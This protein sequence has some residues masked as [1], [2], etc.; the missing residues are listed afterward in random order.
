[1]IRPARDWGAENWADVLP[2]ILGFKRPPIDLY[3]VARHRRIRRLSFRFIIPRGMMV[4]VEGGFDVYLRDQ[5]EKDADISRAET[6]NDL[7]FRQRFSLAHEIAHTRFYRFSD[8]VPSPDAVTPTWRNLED[9]CDRMAGCILIPT[10]LLKQKIR[11]YGKH[12]DG[13]FVRSVASDFRTSVTVALERLRVVE[14]ASSF[15]RC[16]LLA[17]RVQGDAEIRSLFFGL[18]L[19]PVLPRP[20]KYTRISDWLPNFPRRALSQ[21]ADSGSFA[22]RTG[23][24][25]TFTTTDLGNS[26]RFLLELQAA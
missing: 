24:T 26:G 20:E 16:I 7:S 25:I 15:D 13:E 1:L 11:D 6:M 17:Q 14:A 5:A 23:R 8:S 12:I 9:N 21:R 10:Y 18:G 4:P 2:S 19:S 3:A 22:A